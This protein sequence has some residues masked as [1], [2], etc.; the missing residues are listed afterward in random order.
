MEG[1]K[2][3]H[4]GHGNLHRLQH[5]LHRLH[6]ALVLLGA[7]ASQLH[8]SQGDEKTNGTGLK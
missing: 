5:L 8:V 1:W 7:A 2:G 6:R 3:G 4:L